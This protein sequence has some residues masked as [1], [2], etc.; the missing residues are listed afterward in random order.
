MKVK[1]RMKIKNKNKKA[2]ELQNQFVNAINWKK[3]DQIIEFI[4]ID[5][6]GN[7]IKKDTKEILRKIS[8]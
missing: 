7:L 6:N 2:I 1:L 5:K 8:K 4:E 3:L